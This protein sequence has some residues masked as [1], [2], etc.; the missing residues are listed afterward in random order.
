MKRKE[1]IANLQQTLETVREFNANTPSKAE[2]NYKV[3]GKVIEEFAEAL[4]FLFG[5]EDIEEDAVK[6]HKTVFDLEPHEGS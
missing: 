2:L 3:V 4:L 1:I 6:G 5:E